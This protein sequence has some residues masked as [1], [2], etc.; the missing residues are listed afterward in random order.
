MGQAT[1]LARYRGVRMDA[2]FFEPPPAEPEPQRWD[3]PPWFQPPREEIAALVPE[4]R[5]LARNDHAGVV[6]LLSHI[7][8]FS[9][10]C[11]LRVRISVHNRDHAP[12]EDWYDLQDIVMAGRRH[13]GGRPL[14]GELPDDLLRFG[15]RFSD[16]SKA[17]TTAG[18]VPHEL[19]AAPKGP[20]LMQQGGGGSGSDGLITTNWA[21]WLWPLPPAEAFDLIFEW[22]AM[23][24][25]M[26]RVDIDGGQIRRAAETV[27]SFWGDA[28]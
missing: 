11:V 20:V 5:I 23:G 6:I 13:H 9:T 26:Q 8:V 4:R 22:P 3:P 2:D 15:V 14:G 17:T 1:Q 18:P 10:G 16:G 12:A 19:D 25:A 28:H 27:Q 7:D 24:V 21:L